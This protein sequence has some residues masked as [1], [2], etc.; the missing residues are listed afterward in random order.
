MKTVSFLVFLLALMLDQICIN[1][2]MA[3]TF[4]EVIDIFDFKAKL[5]YGVGTDW[6]AVLSPYF[7]LCTP[8]STTTVQT[9][10]K[11]FIDLN[12]KGQIDPIKLRKDAAAWVNQNMNA[13][14]IDSDNLTATCFEIAAH[15]NVETTILS[16]LSQ[17]DEDNYKK[18]LYEVLGPADVKVVSDALGVM[19]SKYT[20]T[21]MTF[22]TEL[23]KVDN[24]KSDFKKKM[25]AL[26]ASIT[27]L[28]RIAVNADIS[29]AKFKE[30]RIAIAV[31]KKCQDKILGHIKTANMALHGFYNKRDLFVRVL[32]GKATIQ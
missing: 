30:V 3:V 25:D 4:S 2:V 24:M 8:K 29:R 20:T 13:I 27:S 15:L 1:G 21:F 7:S 10:L 28:S 16:H 12:L 26:C 5:A 14:Y 22:A 17:K 31:F 6:K 19:R 23:Q 32:I 9:S 11:P 18:W